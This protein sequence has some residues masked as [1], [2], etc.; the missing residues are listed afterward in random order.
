MNKRTCTMPDCGKPHRA[1]GLC[2]SHYNQQHQ[3][4]R[5]ATHTV[6]CAYCGTDCEKN[7][8][9]SNRYESLYCSLQC[10]D[11]DRYGYSKLP[12]DHWALWAGKTS[13][14][15]PPAKPAVARLTDCDWCGAEF[16][17]L[18]LVQRYCSKRCNHKSS[19][20]RRRALE[21]GAA[22]IY[23]W[24]EVT[25]I[26]IGI[27]RCC[28]Y[29]EQ[30]T[31]DYEPDHVI[32]LARGGSNSIT[33]IVPSCKPCNSDKRDLTLADWYADRQRRG[34][35]LRSLST[36]ITHLTHALLVAA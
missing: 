18:K 33:N 23:T 12:A 31:T 25:R 10:R 7:P 16:T 6:Q 32:P 3:P 4:N 27:G 34:L 5:H 2:G 20:A 21:A 15:N 36:R 28:A 17:T 29:C 8:W 1:R 22:G 14:W 30:S 35:P 26:W 9:R 13:K 11:W 24:A 19:R